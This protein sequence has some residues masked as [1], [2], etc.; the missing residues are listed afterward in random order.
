M[1]CVTFYEPF[2]WSDIGWKNKQLSFQGLKEFSYKIIFFI[3]KAFLKSKNTILLLQKRRTR[4]SFSQQIFRQHADK[5]N[6][7][8][9]KNPR[10]KK[11]K[12]QARVLRPDRIQGKIKINIANKRIYYST[13]VAPQSGKDVPRPCMMC[14]L[15]VICTFILAETCTVVGCACVLWTVY[16]LDLCITS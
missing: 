4:R 3:R 1:Q 15:S 16:N 6:Y 14:V 5:K 12:S 11:H 13:L 10:E 7:K 8:T 2:V 9:T